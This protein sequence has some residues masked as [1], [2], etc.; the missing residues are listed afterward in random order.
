MKK[1]KIALVFGGLSAERE[2]SL[3]SGAAIGAALR[4]LG[5]AVHEVDMGR[6][7]GAVL[8]K[9]KP[10]V[11]F[12]ALHGTYGEDGCLQGVCEILGI[13]YTHSGVL[14]S[15]VAMDKPLTN[16]LLSEEGVRCPRGAVYSAAQ[17]PKA[18][19]RTPCVIKPTNNGSSVGVLILG[20]GEKLKARDPILK[21]AP[22]F[23]V[24]DYIAGK[25]LSVAVLDGKALGVIEIAPKQ[26]FYDYKNKYTSGMTDY[27]LPP[28]AS[29]KIQKEA[30]KMA[31]TAHNFLRCR[32]V[33]RSDI[34]YDTKTEKLYFLE[35]NTHPGMT[36]F[37]LV[38]KIAGHQGMEFAALIE[39]LVNSATL[40][41]VL[42]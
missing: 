29:S 38:P 42:R 2:V 37:S 9:L 41:N 33:T 10:D 20:K 35:I 7:V 36:Q 27:I 3:K 31:E 32:G 14:A 39:T 6:D 5:H 4:S 40:D 25:E 1:K 16:R 22:T 23:L 13:P 8:G 21:T 24:E 12:N 28:R 18:K 34:R 26:G 19:L 15:S 11:V 30:M 17:L